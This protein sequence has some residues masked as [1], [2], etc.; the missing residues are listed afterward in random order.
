MKMTIRDG[1]CETNSSSM[2]SIVVTKELGNSSFLDYDS[3][4][5]FKDYLI[6]E[7]D[8][9]FER[10]PFQILSTIKDKARYAIASAYK[11]QNKI[12]QIIDIVKDATG[13]ELKVKKTR[14]EEYRNAETKEEV[15]WYDV[16]WIEDPTDPK[17]E[18]VILKSEIELPPDQWTEIEWR[19]LEEW[20]GYV[21]HQSMDLL[22]G[23]IKSEGIT[24]KEF[25]MEKKYLVV[26]DGDEYCA[27]DN[28]KRAGIINTDNIVKE[29]PK[30]GS[31]DYYLWMEKHKDD[32]ED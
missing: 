26:I 32:E 30:S 1:C 9:V 23:F 10:Y 20:Q 25:L 18:V 27:F 29:F 24:L 11:D 6:R 16:Q 5:H 2:H 7:D 28:M 8:I 3:S 21:D 14:T 17:S 13:T 15:P 22:D 12:Q 19:E 4:Y 31:Y